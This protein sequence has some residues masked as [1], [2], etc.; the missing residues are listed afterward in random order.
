MLSFARLALR[1]RA[2]R[3]IPIGGMRPPMSQHSQTK[4]VRIREQ[5]LI[6]GRVA[7][8]SQVGSA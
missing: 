6:Q 3:A 5:L 7:A 2:V 4:E 1:N 8:A